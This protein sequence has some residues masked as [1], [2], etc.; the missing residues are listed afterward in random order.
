MT[1]CL[2]FFAWSASASECTDIRLDVDGVMAQLPVF[3]QAGPDWNQDTNICY[4]AAAAQLVDAFRHQKSPSAKARLISPWWV[5]TNY[6]TLYKKG[7]D[8]LE[9]GE[10]GKALQAMKDKGVCSQE[11]L[12]EDQ[13][14]EKVVHFYH[15]LKDFFSKNI[16]GK[17]AQASDGSK[18][19]ESDA[20][21]EM[22]ARLGA[23]LTESEFIKDPL[24]AS[25]IS[26]KARKA[27]SFVSF[28]ESIFGDKCNGKISSESAFNF[29]RIEFDKSG[30][31]RV[32]RTR[33][34][35]ATLSATQPLEASICS[36]M[37]REPD[38]RGVT[39]QGAYSESCMRHSVMIIGSRKR[40]G[41]C[42]Y[43]VR[44]MYGAGS[45]AR[46]I[47]GKPWYNPALECQGGQLWIPEQPLLNNTWGLTRIAIPQIVQK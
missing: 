41:Q 27:T 29:Q 31:S 17:K 15:L 2:L 1:L 44:D 12:F 3:D 28:V 6:S 20:N 16:L 38:Y 33:L 23:L 4:A 9:F 18:D 42:D 22:T 24:K 34:I 11:D 25:E 40:K 39:S 43:L 47:N 10:I 8:G 7:E 32:E 30:L 5:A 19:T 36:Q 21:N 35:H 46:Q 45:C 37:L 14:P 13:K 26:S